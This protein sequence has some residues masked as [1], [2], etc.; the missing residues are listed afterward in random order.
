MIVIRKLKYRFCPP[1]RRTRRKRM[2]RRAPLAR[3][4]GFILLL[5]ALGVGMWRMEQRIGDL[6][7]QTALSQLNGEVTTLCNRAVQQTLEKCQ[8]DYQSLITMEKNGEGSVSSLSTNF[9]AV[10]QLKSDLALRIQEG[11][12]QLDTIHAGVPVGALFSDKILTG[13]GFSVP[14]RVI[15]TNAIKVEFF[16]DFQSAGINQ[17]RHKLMIEVTVPA[18]VAAPLCGMDTQV[19]TQVPVAETVIVGSVP[20]TYLQVGQ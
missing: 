2:Q 6:A 3:M 11:L 14:V 8:V 1:R 17:T 15:A 18:R 12:N 13:V 20:G 4:A 9:G 7:Q 16:D 5:A 10:N 19:V